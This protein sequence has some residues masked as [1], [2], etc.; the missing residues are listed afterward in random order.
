MSDQVN[1]IADQLATALTGRFGFLVEAT[2]PTDLQSNS[3]Y[4]TPPVDGSMFDTRTSPASF[5]RPTC[6]FDLVVVGGET[7]RPQSQRWLQALFVPVSQFLRADCPKIAGQ[8]APTVTN[9]RLGLI[10]QRIPAIT[11]ELTPILM[12]CN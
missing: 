7:D 12:E 5:A 4:L 6:R 11:F 9:A 8:V 10:D 3:G 2:I 1:E